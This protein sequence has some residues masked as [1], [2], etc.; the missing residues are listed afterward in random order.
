[1]KTNFEI[2][3]NYAI[4]LNGLHIDLHNNF[5]FNRI[6]DNGT[7]F[8]IIFSKSMG[9]WVHAEELDE[10]T[11]IHKNVSFKF[12]AEGQNNDFPEDEG[13]LS[14]IT[15]FPAS[16]RDI[17]DGFLARSK[18]QENDDIIYNFENEKTF[19]LNCEE[20]ELVVK[21]QNGSTTLAKTP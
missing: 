6:M 13:I 11:F 18:P 1:M 19:R 3:E 16:M 7:D 2:E 4:I 21:K 8:H 9:D 20:V 15:F 17:T 5:V 14:F 10:L 12:Y